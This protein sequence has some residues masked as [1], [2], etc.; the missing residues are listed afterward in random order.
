M[1][2]LDVVD[3]V[4]GGVSVVEVVFVVN[5]SVCAGPDCPTVDI[6]QCDPFRRAPGALRPEFDQ[7]RDRIGSRNQLGHEPFSA[8]RAV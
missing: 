1:V 7:V 3:F 4:Q 5:H 2:V 8:V 6:D